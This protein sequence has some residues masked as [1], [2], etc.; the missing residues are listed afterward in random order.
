MEQIY[1]R[2]WELA[3]PHYQ[4]GRPMDID[5]IEWMMQ[6]AEEVCNKENLDK[7]LF[8]PLVILHDVGYSKVKDPK[9]NSYKLD[10]RKAHMKAGA[11]LSEQILKQLNFD[12]KKTE[13]IAH[14]VSI[15][16]NWALGDN[17]SYLKDPLLGAF[18]DLDFMWMATPKGFLAL[19]KMLNKSSAEMLDYLVNNDK[20]TQR[21]WSNPSTQELFNRYIQDRQK[22]IKAEA[23]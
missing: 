21:P 4:K 8:V 5:H 15:H 16:D 1:N 14:Y 7:T 10:I 11:E 13:K 18:N 19:M 20:L 23:I 3:K 22:Q 12:P 9:D 6:A 2:I 17:E